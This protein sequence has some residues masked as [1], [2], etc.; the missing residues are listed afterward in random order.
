[1]IHPEKILRLF[2][3]SVLLVP[4][5]PGLLSSA[6]VDVGK[7][8]A[9]IAKAREDWSVPG[10]AVAIVKDGEVVLAGGYGDRELGA[11]KPVDSDTLF[12][13]ASNSK[14]FT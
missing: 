5:L 6:E 3:V 11:D 4:V 7:L 12:A 8:S 1:M 13:I 2:L 9:Y 14:A 10:L